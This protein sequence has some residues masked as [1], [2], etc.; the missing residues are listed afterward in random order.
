MQAVQAQAGK[1]LTDA[2]AADLIVD[3]TQ[4]RAA[5]GCQ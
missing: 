1:E 4:I 5:L 2:Q 3:I